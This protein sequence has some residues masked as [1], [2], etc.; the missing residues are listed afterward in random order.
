[1][2]LN[3]INVL[4]FFSLFELVVKLVSAGEILKNFG[5]ENTHDRYTLSDNQMYIIIYTLSPLIFT[6]ISGVNIFVLEPAPVVHV[7]MQH[8]YAEG[9]VVFLVIFTH[10]FT[11][12]SILILSCIRQASYESQPFVNWPTILSVLLVFFYFQSKSTSQ[13][14]YSI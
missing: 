1:M 13:V 6:L 2:F 5:N 9:K 10:V 3:I 14:Y 8:T 7:P 4:S 12:G 11:A